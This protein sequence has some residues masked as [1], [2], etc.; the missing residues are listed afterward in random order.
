M[1]TN[2]KTEPLENFLMNDQPFI[3]PYCGS[4]TEELASFYHTNTKSLIEQCLNESCKLVC[5]IS[6]E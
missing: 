1:K 4:R 2:N 6:D 5:S 3:C